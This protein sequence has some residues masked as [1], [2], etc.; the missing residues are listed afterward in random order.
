MAS[1]GTYSKTHLKAYI[2]PMDGRALTQAEHTKYVFTD[3][4]RSPKGMSQRTGRMDEINYSKR[5]FSAI[6]LCIQI[7]KGFSRHA[8]DIFAS[9]SYLNRIG[10]LK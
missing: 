8:P 2:A 10:L 9:F 6:K 5:N 1:T 4:Y 7:M 3:A